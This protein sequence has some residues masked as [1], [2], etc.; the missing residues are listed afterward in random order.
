MNS[1]QLKKQQGFSLLELSIAMSILFFLSA[2]FLEDKAIKVAEEK[3]KEA[4]VDASVFAGAVADF[5]SVNPNA[6][7]AVNN[8]VDWLKDAASCGGAATAARPYLPCTFPDTLNIGLGAPVTT[9]D[10]TGP[11]STAN[12]NFGIVDTSTY[13][14]PAIV[15]ADI[16]NYANRIHEENMDSYVTFIKEDPALPMV[17]SVTAQVDMTT[18]NIYLRTDGT[19]VMT[20]QLRMEDSALSAHDS[21][22]LVG[23]DSTGALNAAAGDPVASAN[24]NDI[25]IRSV[26][27]WASDIYDLAEDAFTLAN[28]S[29]DQSDQAV[30]FVTVASHG[31][32]IV[33]PTCEAALTPQLFVMQSNVVTDPGSP[34]ALSGLEAWAIDNGPDWTVQLKAFDAS[35]GAGT[36]AWIDVDNARGNATIMVKCSS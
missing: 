7:A 6:P 1:R 23:M 4:A 13:Q 12:I 24:L 26:G 30:R 28:E 3:A 31:T 33:K 9:I 34:Q 19:G 15:A 21:W 2:L 29:K 27:V 10:D 11:A 8:G 14:E 17:G 5:L 25:Y 35:A 22:A 20:G 18:N 16:V 36:G 32:V